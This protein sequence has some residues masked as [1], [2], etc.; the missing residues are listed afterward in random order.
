VLATFSKYPSLSVVLTIATAHLQNA[1]TAIMI[2][3]VAFAIISHVQHKESIE[4]E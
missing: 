2:A 4:T 3:R 1:K